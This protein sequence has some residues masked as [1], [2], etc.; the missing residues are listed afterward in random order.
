M[1]YTGLIWRFRSSFYGGEMFFSPDKTCLLKSLVRNPYKIN[2]IESKAPE[3]PDS[4]RRAS[5]SA[6]KFISRWNSIRDNRH[7]DQTDNSSQICLKESAV[8]IG[9]MEML[10]QINDY[11]L[12]KLFRIFKLVN[13]TI[14]HNPYG[15]Y[16]FHLMC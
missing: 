4:L 14:W 11:S 3:S 8:P 15:N 12:L 5:V 6:N 13:L 2:L 10:E 7:N 9:C 16:W 1:I